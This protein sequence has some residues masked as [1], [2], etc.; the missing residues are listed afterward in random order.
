M[1][2]LAGRPPLPDKLRVITGNKPRAA[3][4]GAAVVQPEVE[5][6]DCPDHLGADARKEWARITPELAKLGLIALIDQAALESYCCAYGN[7]VM[8]SRELNKLADAPMG[9]LILKSPNGYPFENTLLQTQARALKQMNSYLV[10]FGMSPLSR[11]R[12]T[13]GTP[14]LPLFPEEDGNAWQKFGNR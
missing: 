4:Q 11:G 3:V 5:I 8:A 14:Q 1:T 6:P 2:G 9:G 13:A 12:V 7:Y 10:H